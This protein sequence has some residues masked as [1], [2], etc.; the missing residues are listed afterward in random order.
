MHLKRKLSKAGPTALKILF[1]LFLMFSC[2]ELLGPIKFSTGAFEFEICLKIW[3]QGQTLIHFPPLGKITAATHW[4]PLDFH[5]LLKHIHLEELASLT[6]NIPL[7]NFWSGNLFREIKISVFIYIFFL[8]VLVFLL[9][10]ISP[11]FITRQHVGK[12]EMLLMGLVNLLV[13]MSFVSIGFLS[14]DTAAFLEAEYQGMLEAAPWVLHTL[15]E[16]KNIVENIGVQFAEV[17]KNISFLEKEMRKNTFPVESQNTIRVLHVSDIH[18][19]PAAFDFIRRVVDTFDVQLIIDTGDLVDYGTDLELE[20]FYQNFHEIKI[21]YIFIPGNHDS[22]LVIAQLENYKNVIVLEDGE[23][24]VDNLKISALADPASSST[25]PS[26]SDEAL[27]EERAKRLAENV[28]GS[29]GI[30]IIAAHNPQLFKYLRRD[31]NLLLGGHMHQPFVQKNKEYIEINAGTTGASG[32]RGFQ[33]MKINFSLVL[34]DFSYVEQEQR[35]VPFSA[36]LI[37]VEQFP[38][39][40]S[41]ERYI[42]TD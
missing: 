29:E 17:V 3:G 21:P 16:G 24:E 12:G 41:L 32:I 42:F 13:L 23:I 40:F 31:G 4:P 25:A 37:K 20:L 1:S 35:Y 34:L 28:A 9:G 22:P 2:I 39:N 26:L 6:G 8:F 15:Q 11:L 19:N 18:N 10:M 14:Y 30:T 7:T 36:D 33:D 5:L 38:L 27:L